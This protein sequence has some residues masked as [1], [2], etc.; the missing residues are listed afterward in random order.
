MAG[1]RPE[2]QV[3]SE[4]EATL[5]TARGTEGQPLSQ[6]NVAVR[7]TDRVIEVVVKSAWTGTGKEAR[8]GFD[9]EH[10]YTLSRL[11]RGRREPTPSTSPTTT[12]PTPRRFRSTGTARGSSP[13]R[14]TSTTTSSGRHGRRWC[15]SS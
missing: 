6:R 2:I 14:P 10:P 9:A 13:R 7:A 3:L 11:A 1:V 15:A 5:F 8:R 4:A 12:S